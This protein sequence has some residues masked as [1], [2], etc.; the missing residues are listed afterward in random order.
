MPVCS[1]GVSMPVLA[2]STGR[3]VTNGDNQLSCHTH[4]A[5]KLQQADALNE[6][7]LLKQ[8]DLKR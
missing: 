2:M 5:T 6:A 8:F 1:A 7:L 3:V 4:A